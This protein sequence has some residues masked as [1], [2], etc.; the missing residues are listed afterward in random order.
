LQV[1]IKAEQGFNLTTKNKTTMNFQ[2]NNKRDLVQKVN[3]I[4]DIF[5]TGVKITVEGSIFCTD[6]TT[7]EKKH[8]DFS[9][10]VDELCLAEGGIFIYR[11]FFEDAY[12][13]KDVVLK[14][15]ITKANY[16]GIVFVAEQGS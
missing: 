6:P 5:G 12:N 13:G 8:I 7:K 10:Y 2:A 4:R 1:R 15:D 14:F 16:S 11:D 3:A 9:S